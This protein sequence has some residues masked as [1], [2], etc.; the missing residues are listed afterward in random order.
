MDSHVDGSKAWK[1]LHWSDA[2]RAAADARPGDGA[3]GGGV[4][5]RSRS[6]SHADS[7]SAGRRSNRDPGWRGRRRDADRIPGGRLG[8]LRDGVVP[9]SRWHGARLQGARP[10]T[11]TVRRAEV[12][13]PGRARARAQVRRRGAGASARRARARVQGVRGRQRARRAVHR[14][15]A[16]R[17]RHAGA[18]QRADVARGQGPCH[19]QGRRRGPRR[20]PGRPDPSRPQARQRDGR[21]YRDR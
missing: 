3:A 10:A 2:T 5:C 14:D 15:A 9:R 19:A 12:P 16:H 6:R 4:R 17:R 8:P 1:R 18:G 11:S 13:R 7:R 20:A 21:A